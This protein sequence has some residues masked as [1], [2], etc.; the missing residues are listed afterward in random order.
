MTGVGQLFPAITCNL[1]FCFPK[2]Q[3]QILW[4]GFAVLTMLSWPTAILTLTLMIQIAQNYTNLLGISRNHWFRSF[5]VT[6]VMI[7]DTHMICHCDVLCVSRVVIVIFR[8][9]YVRSM[10]DHDGHS[11]VSLSVSSTSGDIVSASHQGWLFV[12]VAVCLWW[13]NNVP[14]SL[15]TKCTS[16]NICRC[17]WAVSLYIWVCF[18][19]NVILGDHKYTVEIRDTVRGTEGVKGMGMGYPLPSWQGGQEECHKLPSGVQGTAP[20]ENGFSAFW[21]QMNTSDDNELGVGIRPSKW[22]AATCD[23]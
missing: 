22:S 19:I 8:L 7:H 23:L 11:I 9:S 17:I 2:M 12:Y 4:C 5:T 13:C 1:T 3:P 14:V 10:S 6:C 15:V 18:N 21:V 20:T 16:L